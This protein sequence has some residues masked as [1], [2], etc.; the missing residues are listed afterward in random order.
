MTCAHRCMFGDLSKMRTM[1]PLFIKVIRNMFLSNYYFQVSF[2]LYIDAWN[3]ITQAW[4]NKCL[5]L[6]KP[7]NQRRFKELS[8]P[9]CPAI[10]T[11]GTSNINHNPY[12]QTVADGF[13]QLTVGMQGL[14]CPPPPY[15]WFIAQ[16]IMRNV[17]HSNEKNDVLQPNPVSSSLWKWATV[18]GF[19]SSIVRARTERQLASELQWICIHLNWVWAPLSYLF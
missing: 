12:Q 15:R 9:G 2:K 18:A 14:L 7:V 4:V 10:K 16:Y 11:F 6:L 1:L 5:H 13:P 3:I 19:T 8:S 17:M